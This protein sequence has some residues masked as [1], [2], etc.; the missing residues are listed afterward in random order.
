MQYC[1][2]AKQRSS[3]ILRVFLSKDPEVLT[4]AFVVYVRPILEYFSPVWSPSTVTYINKLGSVQRCFTKRLLGFHKLSY[5]TGLKT[6]GLERL[7]IRR[8]HADLTMCY[9]IVHNLVNIPFDQFS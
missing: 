4:K 8:L 1:S 9:K 7:E 2:K 5:E 3:Q 6:L